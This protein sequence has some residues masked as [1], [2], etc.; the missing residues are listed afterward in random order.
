MD[1]TIDPPLLPFKAII[2]ATDFLECSQNAGSYAALLARRFDAGLTVAHAFVLTTPAM[3][4]EAETSS[5]IKSRQRL[6][7]ETALAAAAAKYGEGLARTAAVLLEGDAGE[8]I[9]RLAHKLAPSLVV[10]GTAGR[11]RV[12]RGIVGSMAETILRANEGPSLIVGPEVPAC[13]PDEHRFRRVLFAT[14]LSS[15]AARGAA[16]AAA[17][18]R[19][20]NA[21]LE[22]LHVVHTEDADHPGGLSEIQRRFEAML[23]ELIPREA[24]TFRNPHGVVE[25]GVTHE[26]IQERLHETQADLLVLAIHKS[27]HLWL[28]SRLSGVFSIIANAPCPVL[29]ITG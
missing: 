10:L 23:D 27:S 19:V 18:A 20:F 16:Y 17:I 5:C 12:A 26:Q 24:E 25:V 3:E 1:P 9:P 13:A 22:V 28:A 6:D 11:G 21:S 14:G 4:A 8:Q 7:L 2:Y 15:V 29:T